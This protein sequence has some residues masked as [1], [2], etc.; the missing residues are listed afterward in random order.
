MTDIGLSGSDD[1]DSRSCLIDTRRRW[2]EA[3]NG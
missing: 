3:K 1:G 2:G